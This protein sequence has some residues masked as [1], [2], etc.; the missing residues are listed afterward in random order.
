M[1]RK[2][3]SPKLGFSNPRRFNDKIA[4]QQMRQAEHEK[5]VRE[6][7]AEVNA[8]I[9]AVHTSTGL[10]CQSQRQQPHTSFFMH[11]SQF[12][13]NADEAPS[14]LRA[15]AHSHPT[16]P[17]VCMASLQFSTMPRAALHSNKNICKTW[18]CSLLVGTQ[19]L[20]FTTNR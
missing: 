7:R 5:Q 13:E 19:R 3:S 11:D 16:Q 12:H 9:Q 10:S 14:P 4:L 20:P 1:T 17:Q 15:R 8:H 2:N 18:K 6:I